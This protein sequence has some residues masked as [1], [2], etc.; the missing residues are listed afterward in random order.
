MSR[1]MFPLTFLSWPPLAS[2]FPSDEKWQH[3]ILLELART[4]FTSENVKPERKK[5]SPIA[6]ESVSLPHVKELKSNY[7]QWRFTYKR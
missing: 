4:E 7:V 5:I 3:A 6:S 1:L 2:N